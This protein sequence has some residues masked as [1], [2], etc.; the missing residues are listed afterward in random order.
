MTLAQAA[1]LSPESRVCPAGAY[2]DSPQELTESRRGEGGCARPQVGK[3]LSQADP[4]SFSCCQAIKVGVTVPE[5]DREM[6][7]EAILLALRGPGLQRI[8]SPQPSPCTAQGLLFT[9]Y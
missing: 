9:R 1:S 3:G 8:D 5:M 7:Y 2:V 4:I 6:L